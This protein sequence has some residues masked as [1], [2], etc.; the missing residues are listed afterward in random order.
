[1]VIGALLMLWN[2][3]SGAY[4]VDAKLGKR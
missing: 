1:V 2:A 3:G 4:S